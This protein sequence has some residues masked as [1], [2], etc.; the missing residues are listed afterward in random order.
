MLAAHPS[1]ARL[2]D[3]LAAL[4]DCGG[5]E[6]RYCRAVDARRMPP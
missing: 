4:G 2:A 1:V 5:V 6:A 3:V